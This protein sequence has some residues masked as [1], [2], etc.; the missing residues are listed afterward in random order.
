M[1]ENSKYKIYYGLSETKFKSRNANHKKSFKNGKYKTDFELSYKI[2]ELKEQKKK[3][4]ISWEILGI[5]QSYSTAPKRCMLCLNQ[6]LAMALHKQDK[7]S[8]KCTEII[9]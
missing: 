3:V 1:T 8:N 5:H 7:I 9:R 4:N 6:K 2:W